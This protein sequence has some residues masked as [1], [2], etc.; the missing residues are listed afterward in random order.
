MGGGRLVILFQG[1]NGIRLTSLER[2][3]KDLGTAGATRWWDCN[4]IVGRMPDRHIR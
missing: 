2:P 4:S 1:V 3:I